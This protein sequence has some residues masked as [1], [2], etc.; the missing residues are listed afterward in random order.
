MGYFGQ[1]K[2]QLLFAAVDIGFLFI[3]SMP[4][5][6]L[7]YGFRTLGHQPRPKLEGLDIPEMCCP[8]D[9]NWPIHEMHLVSPLLCRARG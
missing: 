2:M 1:M 6:N 9:P 7:Q 4:S 8:A 3:C 5:L